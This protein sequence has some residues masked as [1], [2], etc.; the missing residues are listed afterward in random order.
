MRYLSGAILLLLFSVSIMAGTQEGITPRGS[1]SDYAVHTELDDFALGACLLTPEQVRSNFASDLNRGYVVIEVSIYPKAG[2]S[3]E[4]AR[5]DFILKKADGGVL[6][7]PSDPKTVA[8]ILQKTAG[9]DRDV[10]LY[11]SVAVGYESGPRAYDPVTGTQRGRGVYIA[12]GVGVG[13]GP[14]QSGAS[15]Q[16]RK[17]MEL[18]L[19]EKGFPEGKAERPF[20][21]YLYFPLATKQK[22]VSYLLEYRLGGEKTVLKLVP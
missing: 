2:K 12:T 10:T 6:A 11:P 5:R 20:C 4:V 9:S 7:R 3:F 8:A 22:A 17:T 1:A 15:E 19:S 16:D 14:S 18:E 13:V 21:G